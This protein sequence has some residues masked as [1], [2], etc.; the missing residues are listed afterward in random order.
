[1]T[2]LRPYDPQSELEE[3][4]LYLGDAYEQRRLERSEREVEE[5][6][7]RRGDEG[8][9]YRTSEAYLYDLTVFAMSGTKTPYL[10]ALTHFVPAGT[11]VLD[12]GCGIG[13]DGLRLIDMGYEVA[14]ADFDNPSIR[15]LRWRLQRRGIEAEIYDLDR[16]NIP[17]TFELAYAFD[18]IEHVD[19]PFG[20]LSQMES[21]AR[22]V[23]INFLGPRADDTTLHH[24]ELPVRSLLRYAASRRLR[25]YRRLHG[26]SHLVLF[27]S[28]PVAGVGRLASAL[29]LVSGR[30]RS[31]R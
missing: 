8:T 18:V 7:E 20:F 30:L 11:R 15:Y 28:G 22:N 17:P 24:R 31:G 26:R 9:L 2:E 12:Y 13:S 16:V 4:K 21:L 1:M 27:A 14:F 5:E 10:A 25:Y 29:R 23:F 3:L 19:E 6:L